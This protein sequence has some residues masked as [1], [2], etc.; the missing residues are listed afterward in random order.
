VLS[1][2]SWVSVVDGGETKRSSFAGVLS[3]SSGRPS[4][5]TNPKVISTCTC[6]FKEPFYAEFEVF[7]GGRLGGGTQKRLL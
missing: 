2:G 5:I 4:Y 7:G 3:G 1:P 6:F